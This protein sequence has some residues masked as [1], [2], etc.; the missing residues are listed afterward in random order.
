MPHT[1]VAKLPL[2]SRVRPEEGYQTSGVLPRLLR[3]EAGVTASQAPNLPA[4]PPPRQPPSQA[5]DRSG[6]V[7]PAVRGNG[8][9]P[10]IYTKV[11]TA[12][13]PRAPAQNATW[14]DSLQITIKRP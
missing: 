11:S 7:L 4:T 2:R 9:D 3:P 12:S 6:V 5:A 14:E 8:E 1:K 10:W 13:A